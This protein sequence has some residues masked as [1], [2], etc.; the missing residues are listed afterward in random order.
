MKKEVMKKEFYVFL[1]NEP[2]SLADLCKALKAKKINILGL[3]LEPTHEYAKIIVDRDDR[4]HG[5][6]AETFIDYLESKVIIV[7]L[8]NTPGSLF[9]MLGKLAKSKINVLSIHILA[10]L[11]KD[12]GN[13]VSLSIRTSDMPK[14]RVVLGLGKK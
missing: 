6:L 11:R 7:D 3:S 13:K 12:Q 4:M 2:G 14:T 5:A 1:K 10:P 8:P 9:T